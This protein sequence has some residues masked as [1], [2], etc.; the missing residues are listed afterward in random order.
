MLL[1]EGPGTIRECPEVPGPYESVLS[2]WS[3]L[4]QT[5]RNWSELVA[6]PVASRAGPWVPIPKD[7]QAHCLRG[8]SF[9]PAG[10]FL[11]A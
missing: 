2:D 10:C 8:P 7:L 3:Q 6:T 1:P 5:S 11:Q 9:M 4:V